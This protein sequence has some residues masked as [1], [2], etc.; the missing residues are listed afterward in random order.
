MKPNEFN[1]TLTMLTDNQNWF[2]NTGCQYPLVCPK[3]TKV[4]FLRVLIN[5]YGIWFEVA[6][7]GK[8]KYVMPSLVEGNVI[9][10]KEYLSYT[11]PVT[12]KISKGV[13][14]TDRKGNEWFAG[15]NTQW[16]M[17]EV[18]TDQNKSLIDIF[19]LYK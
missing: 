18:L 1:T 12:L 10:K 11:N 2:Y 8:I 19:K 14:L 17:Q 7:E 15:E 9:V 6:Y 13:I 4:K 3:G 5:Y 16:E